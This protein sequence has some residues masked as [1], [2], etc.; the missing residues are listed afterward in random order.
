MMID[1]ILKYIDHQRMMIDQ[2]M[3]MKYICCMHVQ[4]QFSTTK[5]IICYHVVGARITYFLSISDFPSSND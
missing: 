5:Y 2:R 1:Y 4:F 3:T